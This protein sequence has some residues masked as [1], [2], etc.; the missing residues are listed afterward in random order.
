[1]ITRRDALIL[2]SA[3]ALMP[4]ADAEGF[5]KRIGKT[6]L[7][8]GELSESKVREGLRE[9]LT[10]GIDRTVKTVGKKDGYFANKAIKILVPKK[11]A[12][13]EKPL[14]KLGHGDK[15]DAFILSMN[16]AAETAAPLAQEIFIDA[17]AN[18]TIAD[19]KTIL[20]GEDTAATQYLDTQ[21]R[22]TLYKTFSPKVKK[23]MD[24]FS[25]GPKY[26]AVIGKTK[27]LPF[28]KRYI[29][30]N[31]EGHTTNKA[32]DG[33]FHILGQEET[34]IRTTPLARS[35][36]LLKKVFGQQS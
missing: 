31:I 29:E 9:A 3:T 23:T 12:K 8:D 16:R 20:K 35:T 14:R 27:S 19:A 24:Q 22:P 2:L 25:V 1:M 15:I 11:F 6:L 34:K 36:D 4:M 17:I 10:V 30:T 18:M 7:G 5:F 21:T 13:A 28:A 33:L 32:L 26:D